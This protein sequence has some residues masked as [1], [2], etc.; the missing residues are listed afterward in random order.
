MGLSIHPP[1]LL[2]VVLFFLFQA[3][4]H[5]KKS[6][7]VYMGPP[8]SDS[9]LLQLEAVTT[10]QYDTLGAVLGSSDK[11]KAAMIYS[12]NKYF[13]GFAAV[14]NDDEAAQIANNPKVI[15]VFENKGRKL[16]T[17]HSWEF[18]GL[19]NNG[20]LPVDS[21][22]KTARYGEDTIIANLDTGVWPESKS[23]S[24]EG[25][26]PIPSK[27][28]GTCQ[29]MGNDAVKCNRKLI[30]VRYFNKGYAAALDGPL[31]GSLQTARDYEGHGSHTLSTA[32]GNIVPGASVLGNGNGAAIMTTAKTRA[33]DRKGI[34]DASNA[35]AIPFAYGAGHV[36]PNRAMD[37]GLIF[38]L[39]VDDYLNY[40]CDRGYNQTMLQ[41][42]SIK[43]HVCP[44]TFALTDFNYP[45][46]TAANL[47]VH[48]VTI[49]RT[50]TNVGS[51]GTYKVRITE[52]TGISVAVTPSVLNFGAT[53]EKQTFKVT[54]TAKPQG[55][56]GFYVFG[57]LLWSDG[58]HN[59]RSPLVAVK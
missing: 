34:L 41:V 29:T 18:M 55:E 27:W 43:P 9:A 40:L 36:Q 57:E 11:A 10:M 3:P 24:D 4:T 42:F 26:G 44:K 28:R 19:E 16:H 20:Q 23:F 35:K 8:S 32:G 30:G 50:V 13:N 46:I 17:T 31:D 12:Y 47:A 52:P 53:G 58:N 51:P 59:V 37:P 5:A 1:L 7:I 21:A 45:S 25:M 2:S 14:L 56:K 48:P 38:D 49:T 33:N 22:W 6:Y 54:L 15:S 39:T